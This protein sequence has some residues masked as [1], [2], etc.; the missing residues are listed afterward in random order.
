MTGTA[1]GAPRT[2]ARRRARGR[3]WGLLGCGVVLA[4]PATLLA[5]RLTGL[6]AGTPFAM[7]MVFFPW[8]TALCVLVLG[9]MV[10]V[11]TLRSWWA[12][13][14][15][16]A[17][18]AAQVA[19]LMPRFVAES[20]YVPPGSVQLRVATVNT[21]G[22]RVDPHA[23]VDLVR[24]GRIDVLAVEQTP[25][26]GSDALDRAGLGALM[27]YR[28]LHPEYD[29]SIYSRHPLSHAGTTR[30]DTAWP[31]TT[32]QVTV[33][34]RRVELVAVHTYYPLGDPKR[35]TR[36]MAALTSLAGRSGPDTVFLGDF[37]ASLDH[38][39]MRRL[40]AAG[41]TD[42][43]D[44]LG[45]G[46]ARTWP[47]GHALVPPLIQLDHVLYGSGL[48]GVSVAERTL[49]GTDHRAVVAV[50]ALLPT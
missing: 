16:A 18:V 45:R 19:L 24:T 34:G 33:G 13:A 25:S 37:N 50:L 28:E 38:T 21:D 36:D 32:A 8:S 29:S 9:V 2:A 17:L 49:P 22:G 3:A 39:P 47:V 42:T 20:R 11:P 12:V 26:R 1:A 5:V 7:P 31:Q 6:D 46:W 30:I 41:L 27:P 40:L 14:V 43:H 44:A 15:V 23:L 10:A 35:W 48:T 4:A